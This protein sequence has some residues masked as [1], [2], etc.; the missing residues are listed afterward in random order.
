[1]TLGLVTGVC[2]FL[3]Y[4]IYFD[5]KRRSDPAFKQKLRESK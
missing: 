5:S 1:M 2:G 4:C 3:A